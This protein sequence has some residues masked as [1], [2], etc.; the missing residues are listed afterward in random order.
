MAIDTAEKRKSVSRITFARLL[1]AVTPNATKDVDWRS[2]AARVYSGN[3]DDMAVAAGNSFRELR[4]RR[5]QQLLRKL[6]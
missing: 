2:Q 4:R 3:T 6:E 5:R 1:P